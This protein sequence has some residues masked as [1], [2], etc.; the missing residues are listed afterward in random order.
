MKIMFI[1]DIHGDLESLKTV[2]SG[3]LNNLDKKEL[4]ETGHWHIILQKS[5]LV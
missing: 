1:S 2:K 4:K 3:Y 5:T